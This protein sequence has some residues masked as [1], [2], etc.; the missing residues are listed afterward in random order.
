MTSYRLI[1]RLSALSVVFMLMALAACSTPGDTASTVTD[2]PTPTPTATTAASP[3]PTPTQC[4]TRYGS[5]YVTTLPDSV[6]MDTNVYAQIELPPQTRYYRDDASGHRF[7][8]MCSAGTADSVT[9]FM[10][11][12]LTQ[13]GWQQEAT[14]DAQSCEI[15]PNYGQPQCWKNGKYELFMGIKSRA[16][17]VLAFLDPAFLP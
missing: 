10:T 4:D 6:F 8:F 12:H 2:T 5:D 14:S 9:T 17:W 16:D 11:Q 3:S 15:V 13:E 7:K 1:S